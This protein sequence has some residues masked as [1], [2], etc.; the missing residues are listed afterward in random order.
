MKRFS[1]YLAL[2]FKRTA[3]TFIM[4]LAV[5]LILLTAAGAVGITVA[6]SQNSGEFSKKVTVGIIGDDDDPLLDL[7]FSLLEQMESVKLIIGFVHY[8][9]ESS[10][11]R[12]LRASKIDSYALLPENFSDSLIS[13]DNYSIHYVMPKIGT[14][15]NEVLTREILGVISNYVVETQAG[16]TAMIDYAGEQGL[17]SE[18]MNVLNL[19]MSLAYTNLIARRDSIAEITEIGFVS[20]LSAAGYF[21]SGFSIFFLLLWGVCSCTY[22]AS[23][24]CFLPKLLYSRG[25]K[26]LLQIICEYLPYLAAAF[27]ML[28]IVLGGA[29]VISGFVDFNIPELYYLLPRDYF[30]MAFKLIPVLFIITSFQFL[31]Y[32]LASG[33]INALMLQL[34]MAVLL[35]Y[36]GGCFYPIYFFLVTV[37]RLADFLP[38]GIA[39]NYFSG[40]LTESLRTRDVAFALGG[41]VV[42]L[43]LS[44]AQRQFKIKGRED[45]Q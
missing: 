14:G 16:V 12:D 41:G 32:E 19:D 30:I 38:A 5:T 15:I 36:A 10:A 3:K 45:Q 22:M 31:L 27:L 43:A 17:S 6:A 20:S 33:I 35:G 29:A 34:I 24:N 9:D 11:L 23:S 44:A 4:V 28:I 25:Y 8:P 21:L 1:N 13:G 2:Q 26:S 39:F 18:K 7:G 37:Q 40:I 42:F